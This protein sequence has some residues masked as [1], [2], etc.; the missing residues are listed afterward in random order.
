MRN[1]QAQVT[2]SGLLLEALAEVESVRAVARATGVPQP[3]LV[4]FMAGRQSLRLDNA[5]AL[6]AYFGIVSRQGKARGR[7]AKGKARK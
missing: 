6:A 5:E 3:C 4:R 2:I 7:A 1:A